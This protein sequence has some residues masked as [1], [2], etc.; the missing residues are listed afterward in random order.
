MKP[1]RLRIF[2]IT[3]FF[4]TIS[5]SITGISL[6]LEKMIPETCYASGTYAQSK[7]LEGI[8]SPLNSSGRFIFSCKA[9]LIWGTESPI[10]E[11]LIY[12]SNGKQFTIDDDHAKPI[13]NR[14]HQHIG[15]LLN[16]IIGGN[17]QYLKK[18]FT[19][20]TSSNNTVLTPKN[21]RMKKFISS[22][23]LRKQHDTS[24]ISIDLLP[25]QRLVLEISDT[26]NYDTLDL[27]SCGKIYTALPSACNFLF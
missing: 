10:S 23:T 9:G 13:N 21:R 4:I 22:I 3:S 5:L 20:S 6:P 14:A 24:I 2:H 7:T 17:A 11:T 1:L 8:K 27:H 12:T 19:E 15:K 26:K 25:E 16:G 18:Y